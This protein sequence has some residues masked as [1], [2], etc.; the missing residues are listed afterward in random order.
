M[1]EIYFDGCLQIRKVAILTCGCCGCSF[2]LDIPSD[3]SAGRMLSTIRKWGWIIGGERL[4]CSN[5]AYDYDGVEHDKTMG[6]GP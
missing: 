6:E 1:N 4:I 3:F 5:C 2:R